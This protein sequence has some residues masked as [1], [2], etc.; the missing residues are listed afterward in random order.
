MGLI[1]NYV[2]SLNTL[3][4]S[5]RVFPMTS[6]LKRS[7]IKPLNFVSQ[8]HTINSGH[9]FISKYTVYYD[10]PHPPATYANEKFQFRSA[11]GSGNNILLPDLGKANMPYS[12]SVQAI[13]PLAATE[14]PEA[15][16]VYQSLLKR[17][18]V[19]IHVDLSDWRLMMVIK[20]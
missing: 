8:R 17:D 7:R 4:S 15:E 13:H 11:D 1:N 12:R 2:H 9:Q 6:F 10:L 20:V 16:Q 14:L 5:C 18:K 3:L 19:C